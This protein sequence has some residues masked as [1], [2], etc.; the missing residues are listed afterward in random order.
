MPV[1]QAILENP[2]TP[3]MRVATSFISQHLGQIFHLHAANI[4]GH[5]EFR[6]VWRAM[7]R[8]RLISA[9][10]EVLAMEGT[11]R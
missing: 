10:A 2:F 11:S 5:R 8:D 7:N 4:Q 9:E 6:Q 1:S 3:G